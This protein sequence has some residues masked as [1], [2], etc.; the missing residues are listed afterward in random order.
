MLD[1]HTLDLHL[2]A[3][4]V[5]D[6]VVETNDAA[7]RC[8]RSERRVSRFD[9]D[10]QRF[11]V[12]EGIQRQHGQCQGAKQHKFLHLGTPS[13]KGK[14]GRVSDSPI[15]EWVNQEIGCCIGG[16]FPIETVRDFNLGH[17]ERVIGI[18]TTGPKPIFLQCDN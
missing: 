18:L 8:F 17:D 3:Q 1:P 12:S 2:L 11:F 5:A 9:T 4:S 14:N 7:I 6:V 15:C 13:V 16:K 10:L